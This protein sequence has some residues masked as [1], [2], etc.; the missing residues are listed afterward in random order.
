M[1]LRDVVKQSN[2][3]STKIGVAFNY[4]PLALTVSVW[5]DL[6]SNL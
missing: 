5:A 1:L 4:L 6:T 3:V 2:M